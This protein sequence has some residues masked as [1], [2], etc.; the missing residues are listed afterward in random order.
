MTSIFAK[1]LIFGKITQF[2]LKK[3]KETTQASI[4]SRR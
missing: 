3:T 4:V 2:L 1:I